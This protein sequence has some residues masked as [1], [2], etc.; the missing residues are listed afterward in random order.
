MKK[1]VRSGKT[2]HVA[3]VNLEIKF[4]KVDWDKMFDP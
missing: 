1:R 3:L 4:H 2:T